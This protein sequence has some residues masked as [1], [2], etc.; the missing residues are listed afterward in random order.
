MKQKRSKE[1]ICA[2]ILEI[3]RDGMVK[4]RIVYGSNTNFR[5]C[6]KYMEQLIRAGLIQEEHLDSQKIYR[7]TNKG[8]DALACYN[9]LVEMV[10]PGGSPR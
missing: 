10:S 1:A 3:C 6:E 9:A 7:T 5:S 8:R 2:E 4:T